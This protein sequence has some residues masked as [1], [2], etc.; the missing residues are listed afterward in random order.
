[1]SCDILT[2]KFGLIATVYQLVTDSRSNDLLFNLDIKKSFIQ[3]A[4]N[5]LDIVN[6]IRG[7]ISSSYICNAIVGG[8]TI[9]VTDNER[10]RFLF[11]SWIYS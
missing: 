3:F 8:D 10:T 6:T 7:G 9:L 5:K 11:K 4:L 2:F 1:M